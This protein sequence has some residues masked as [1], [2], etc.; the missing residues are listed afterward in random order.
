MY[1]KPIFL[2][3]LK[4]NIQTDTNMIS[5]YVAKGIQISP[6]LREWNS[7]RADMTVPSVRPKCSRNTGS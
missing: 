3:G 1:G 4:E 6:V 5:N 7:W 2:K